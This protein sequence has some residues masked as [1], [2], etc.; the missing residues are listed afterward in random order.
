MEILL[1]I[2]I[3]IQLG[4]CYLSFRMAKAIEYWYKSEKKKQSDRDAMSGKR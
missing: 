4:S 3:V 1:S 2:L